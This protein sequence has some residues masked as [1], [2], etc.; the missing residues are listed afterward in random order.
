MEDIALETNALWREA[1]QRLRASLGQKDFETWLDPVRLRLDEN[2]AVLQVPNRF[3]ASWIRERYWQ[4]VSQAL[5]QSAGTDLELGLEISQ[6]E[7]VEREAAPVLPLRPVAQVNEPPLLNPLY[8]FDSFVVGK[9]NELAFAA[10]KAVA[11]QPGRQYNP[12]FIFGGPGLGKTHLITAVGNEI[13]KR[14]PGAVIHYGS[15]EGL[16]NEL[17]Q[18]IRFDGLAR[19]QEKYRQV[20][21]LLLDDI[22]FLAGRERTQEEFFHTFNALYQS[23][24]QIVVTSDKMPKEIPGLEKRLRTR[25][26]WGLLVDLQ[27]PDEETKVAILQKKAAERGLD[28]AHRVAHFLARQPEANVRVL[29][30]YLTRVIAISSFQQ[31]EVTLDLVQRVVGPLVSERQVSIDDVLSAVAQQYGVK[32]ADLKGSRKTRDV[33]LPRQVAMYLARRLTR[34]SFPEIGRSFG[35]K[36]H[37]TVVK[38][39]KR[40]QE[41]LRENPELAEQVRVAERALTERRFMVGP[42]PSES[43][44]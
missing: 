24:K 41:L 15:A 12:L 42:R 22:H 30:G 18:A 1:R 25:F 7:E 40:I 17:I 3:F 27:P 11:D 21:C 2:R 16:S 13:L 14:Q 33:S 9:C 8:T 36:D 31:V 10:C 44:V 37:S 38:G 26:E 6:M 34:A 43:G 28:L 19:F 39:V 5:S 29:E 4:S 35:G 23:G 32:V 20:D